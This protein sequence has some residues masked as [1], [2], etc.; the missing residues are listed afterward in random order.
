MKA[1]KKKALVAFL[2]AGYPDMKTTEELVLLFEKNG[3]DIIELGVPF[4]DPVADGPTIQFSS[5]MALRRGIHLTQILALVKKLRQKTQIPI[6]LMSYLNPLQ[7]QGFAKMAAKA[8]QCGVDGFIIPDLIPE[9]SASLSRLCRGLDLSLIYL[10][11]PNTPAARL[12]T[13]DK[14]S[15]S[16][17]YI[18]SILGVTG[19]R[20]TLPPSVKGY[21]HRTQQCISHPRIIGFGISGP[22]QILQLK[23]YVDGFIVASAFI[24]ILRRTNGKKAQQRKLTD[25]LRSLRSALDN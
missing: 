17:V 14:K 5:E 9:E 1:Q 2:T 12:V 10:V 13:I 21:L 4:S 3:A 22:A 23:Q 6:I 16:F 24:D 18:V 7:R 11:A 25:L 15:D 19:A 8:R 20:A